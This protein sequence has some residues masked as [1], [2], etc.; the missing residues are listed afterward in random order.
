M[1]HH[2]SRESQTTGQKEP[3]AEHPLGPALGFLQRIWQL[4]HVFERLSERM[5]ST[6]G[7]T[8]QQRLVIRCVGKLPG[9][10]PGQ[11]AGL[12]HVDPGT[13]SAALNRLENKG[14]LERRPEPRDR[15]RTVLGLTAAGRALDGPTEGTVEAA[16][17]RLLK[18]ASPDD[19]A[20]TVRVLERLS[21]LV[22]AELQGGQTARGRE[23]G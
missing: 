16:L 14:L 11:L 9:I 1:K 4:N 10:G 6:L 20:S 5:V 7:V 15:R 8:A 13:V 3:A 18:E 21:A 17:E 2:L 19:V 22:E 12:L 23:D